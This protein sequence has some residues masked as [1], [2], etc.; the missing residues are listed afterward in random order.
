MIGGRAVAAEDARMPHLQRYLES[1]TVPGPAPVPRTA[2]RQQ[3]ALH[4]DR[5]RRS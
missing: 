2:V 5:I 4:R 1:R 3:T